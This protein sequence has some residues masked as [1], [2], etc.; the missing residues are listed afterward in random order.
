MSKKL[1]SGADVICLDVKIGDGAFMKTLEDAT[2]LSRLM[3]SI[4]NACGRKVA[5][6]ITGMD[7]PLGFAVGNRLEV[8]EAYETLSGHGPADLEELCLEIGSEMVYRAGKAP[9]AASAKALLRENLHNGVALAKFKEFVAAQGGRLASLDGF[10]SAKLIEEVKAPRA[11]SV[12]TIR[13]LPIGLATMKLGGGRET[14]DD[15]ID[16][17]VGVVLEKKVGAK[18][19]EGETLARIYADAPITDEIRT[20][21]LEAFEIV[22]GTVAIP[23]IIL[24]T[25]R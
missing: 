24:S 21:V 9:S 20:S 15:V 2:R 7:Q 10:V 8:A 12:K 19:K 17:N 13:A 4:G 25:V 5:A 14:K 22:D 16:P 11:G 1:A 18:V 3:V 23:P 6:F